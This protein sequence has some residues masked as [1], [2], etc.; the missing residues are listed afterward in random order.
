VARALHRPYW[1]PIPAFL[2]RLVLGEKAMLV[3]EGQFV[4]PRRLLEAGFPF[5]YPTLD[6]ALD[7]LLGGK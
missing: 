1:F 7:S 6:G 5:R 3:L 4:K 2:L